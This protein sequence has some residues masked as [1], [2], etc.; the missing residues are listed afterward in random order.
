MCGFQHK[1]AARP[2]SAK[3]RRLRGKASEAALASEQ[4]KLV[5]DFKGWEPEVIALRLLVKNGLSFEQANGLLARLLK[6]PLACQTTAASLKSLEA[7]LR[8]NAGRLLDVPAYG[9][10]T[11]IV[12]IPL[13][14]PAD[15]VDREILRA[16]RQA[17]STMGGNFLPSRMPRHAPKLARDLIAFTFRALDIDQLERALSD[18]GLPPLARS[19]TADPWA[20]RRRLASDMRKILALAKEWEP[21]TEFEFQVR[22][23]GAEE[24]ECHLHMQR[25]LAAIVERKDAE[26]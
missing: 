16:V 20:R 3:H 19:P 21:M 14:R 7:G 6:E 15:I 24:S 23:L 25:F 11:F 2:R 17:R 9:L 12:R 8:D 5:A 1:L 13:C 26:T 22:K 10:M 4:S 18:L